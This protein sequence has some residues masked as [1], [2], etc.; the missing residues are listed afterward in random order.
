MDDFLFIFIS[1]LVSKMM[2]MMVFR[3]VVWTFQA[4][5]AIILFTM[6]NIYVLFVF[7]V[8]LY[9]ILKFAGYPIYFIL[10]QCCRLLPAPVR[11]LLRRFCKRSRI[12]RKGKK[13]FITIKAKLLKNEGRPSGMN[14]PTRRNI[15]QIQNEYKEQMERNSSS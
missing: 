12:F 3:P 5:L 8:C 6:R 10:Y 7:A 2:R 9:K 13:L 11:G 14:D 1:R 4:I 15:S